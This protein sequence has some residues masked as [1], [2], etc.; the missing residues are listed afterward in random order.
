MG[1]KVQPTGF[2]LELFKNWES[3]WISDMSDYSNFIYFDSNIRHYLTIL[4]NK[5]RFNF[6]HIKIKK[7]S[8]SLQI[9]VFLHFILYKNHP[10][11]IDLFKKHKKSI[12]RNIQMFSNYLLKN[13]SIKLYFLN[14]TMKLVKKQQTYY[15]LTQQLKKKN[16]LYNRI[17]RFIGILNTV[18]FLQ[19]VKMFNFFV[20]KNLQKTPKHLYFLKTIDLVLRK[21]YLHHKTFLGYKIQFKGRINGRERAKKICFKTG[22]IASQTINSNIKYDYQKI[23]TPSGICG[24]KTWFL[25]ST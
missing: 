16:Q 5:Y 20:V 1:Q 10:F 19:N 7:Q 3:S 4:S 23:R 14:P 2:R 9:Y 22:T 15:K 18:I 21:L 11:Q 25:F 13:Y 24:L 12:E 8:N 17:N 6:S